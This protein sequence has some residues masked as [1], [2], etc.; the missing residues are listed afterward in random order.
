MALQLKKLSETPAFLYSFLSSTTLTILFLM[1]LSSTFVSNFPAT[2]IFAYANEANMMSRTEEEAKALLNWKST[3][4]NQ[5]Q[6]V[7]SSWAGNSPCDW[8]G[9]TCD[10]SGSVAY[11]NLSHHGL[12]G[13]IPESIGNL[14]N[15]SGLALFRNKLSGSIPVGLG[16]LKSL[17][18]L[19]LFTNQLS[20]S[21]PPKIDRLVLGAM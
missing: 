16:E 15:L 11:F 9:I 5:S 8:K 14:T 12:T 10:S 18:D 13:K 17:V 4:D 1:V 19:R 20:G 7:L 21:L 2:T 6:L 3:L